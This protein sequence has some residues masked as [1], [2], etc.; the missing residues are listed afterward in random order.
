MGKDDFLDGIAKSGQD[1]EWFGH[2][3]DK[4]VLMQVIFNMEDETFEPKTITRHFFYYQDYKG[5]DASELIKDL[6]D[7]S[8]GTINFNQ[9]GCII[10]H[11]PI[12]ET[13]EEVFMRVINEAIVETW[14]IMYINRK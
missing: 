11:E 3:L 9:D 4:D 2:T 14:K 6:S 8:N 7:F 5:K 13:E 10:E 1:I 12:L